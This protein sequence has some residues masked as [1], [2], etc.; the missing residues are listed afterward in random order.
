MS[1]GRA[2]LQAQEAPGWDGRA[3]AQVLRSQDPSIQRFSDVTV[4][5][6]EGML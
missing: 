1:P 3:R 5:P 4:H 2:S 6:I